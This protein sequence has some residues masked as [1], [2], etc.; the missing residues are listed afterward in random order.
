MKD[1]SILDQVI[2]L[3]D[4][5]FNW[6]KGN[7]HNDG[8]SLPC[9]ND[10]YSSLNEYISKEGKDLICYGDRVTWKSQSQGYYSKKIGGVVRVVPPFTSPIYQSDPNYLQRQVALN[11]TKR[12]H[13]S[14]VIR[15]DNGRLYWP[16]V[17][18]LKKTN[19]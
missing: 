7:R 15:A 10:L 1:K 5:M 16:R 8:F 14:Y 6:W 12:N 4:A 11:T 19:K 18:A 3:R 9:E 13:E 17:S 2:N